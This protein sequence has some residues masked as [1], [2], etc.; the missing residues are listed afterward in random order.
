MALE[1]WGT[2]WP[3]APDG[4]YKDFHRQYND[5][6]MNGVKFPKLK[7][8]QSTMKAK[9]S[10]AVP[11]SVSPTGKSLEKRPSSIR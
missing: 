8:K 9:S 6:V 7:P 10:E 5:L 4:P 3:K 11:K 1:E 2:K